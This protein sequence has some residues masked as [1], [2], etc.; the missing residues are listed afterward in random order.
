MANK[1]TKQKIDIGKAIELYET[2]LTQEEV[3]KELNT[4]QKV[5]WQRFKDANY[6]CRIAAKRDQ[7]GIKNHMWKGKN[8]TYAAK[9]YRLYKILGMPRKCQICGT[10]D[11]KKKYEW[12]NL[13]GDFD[14]P[15]DY[16]RMCKSCH[17][18]YD[19]KVLNFKKNRKG[20]KP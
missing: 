4:T 11:K 3:A 10:V 8:A 12:A 16:K 2:G 18:K 9:H 15:K 14:N 20:R 19:K 17:A 6:R 13:S 1:Y 5:I 7:W